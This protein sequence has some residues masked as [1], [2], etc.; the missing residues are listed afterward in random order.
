MPN[1]KL[2][3]V[4]YSTVVGEL[5]LEAIIKEIE[6]H[7]IFL[8]S[9]KDK[10]Q[11]RAKVDVLEDSDEPESEVDS[12][13]DSEFDELEEVNDP[14]C[15]MCRKYGKTCTGEVGKVCSFCIKSRHRGCSSSIRATTRKENA[16]M[17]RRVQRSSSS[18]AKII[19]SQSESKTYHTRSRAASTPTRKSI[20]KRELQSTSI[21]TRKK[22]S[23]PILPQNPPALKRKSE[24]PSD[25]DLERSAKKKPDSEDI[26]HNT[27]FKAVLTDLEKHMTA[28]QHILPKSQA[29]INKLKKICEE[30]AN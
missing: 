19:T 8:L 29:F 26:T 20:A 7:R 18:S 28:L 9:L 21:S 23:T 4:E 25:V 17:A 2:S 13:V 22:S 1:A 14:P 5:P 3:G 10:P 30:N 27:E 15:T 12:K 24:G 11:A 16:E 6:D